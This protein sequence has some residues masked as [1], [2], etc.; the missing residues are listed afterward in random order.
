MYEPDRCHIPVTKLPAGDL[1]VFGYG[2]L[3]WRPG[4]PYVDLQAARIHG[5]HRTLCVWS[6]VYRG[7]QSKPGLVLGLDMGG[8]CIGR[9]FRVTAANKIDA[10]NYLYEREMVTAVYV[11]TFVPVRL[12]SQRQVTALTFVVDRAHVQ[13]AGKLSAE[14]AAEAVLRACGRSGD[15]TDYIANTVQ[16]LDELG[17]RD[18]LLHRVDAIVRSG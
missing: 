2:S 6:W 1:W 17:I 3:M 8:S 12:K 18:R 15:N 10:V 9:A 11:P 4:F 16:H 7:T 14:E 5:Y 13:Y